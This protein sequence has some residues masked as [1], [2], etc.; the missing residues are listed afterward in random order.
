MICSSGRGCLRKEESKGKIR[1]HHQILQAAIV[2]P[3]MK[4]VL[5]FSPEPITNKDGSKKQDCEIN[6]GKRIVSKIRKNHPKL[7]III[8]HQITKRQSQ[9]M[10]LPLSIVLNQ[11]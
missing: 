6:A 5:P 8:T 4:Q 10:T 11:N 9:L 7:K 3:D 2:H 1:Y